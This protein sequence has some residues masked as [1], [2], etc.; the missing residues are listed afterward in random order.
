MNVLE[1]KC[2][3]TICCVRCIDH[4]W[5]D[6]AREKCGSNPSLIVRAD[7]DVL[8]KFGHI[9]RMSKESG[10]MSQKL[11]EIRGKERPRRWKDGG[12]EAEIS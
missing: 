4:L 2:L 3:R 6:C 5:N 9:V 8:N 12:R 11:R 10:S 1:M 7:Q